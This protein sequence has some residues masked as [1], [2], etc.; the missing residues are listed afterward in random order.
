MQSA[1]LAV[2]D[3]LMVVGA[4]ETVAAVKTRGSAALLGGA[5][6]WGDALLHWVNVVRRK[7]IRNHACFKHTFYPVSC[8]KLLMFLTSQGIFLYY[9]VSV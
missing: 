6:S 9:L 8:H 4:M 5:C 7:T 2:I 1:H 3:A